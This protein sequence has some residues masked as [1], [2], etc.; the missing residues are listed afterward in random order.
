MWKYV[1]VL[2]AF[3]L[4]ACQTTGVSPTAPVHASR[5]QVSNQQSK[6]QP[7]LY[8]ECGNLER[9]IFATE[10]LTLAQLRDPNR[11]VLYAEDM[12]HGCRSGNV[13]VNGRLLDLRQEYTRDGF[14]VWVKVWQQANG[15]EI[16]FV[17]PW[18]PPSRRFRSYQRGLS[19]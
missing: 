2:A 13:T 3:V 11:S 17:D 19:S 10:N 5:E 6:F 15:Y 8:V 14:Q 7:Q 12:P 1:L 4:S 16:F 18:T 9:T